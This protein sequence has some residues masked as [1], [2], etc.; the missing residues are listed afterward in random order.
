MDEP[1]QGRVGVVNLRARCRG[2]SFHRL[3]DP[4]RNAIDTIRA[5][6][7]EVLFAGR[8]VVEKEAGRGGMGVVYQAFDRLG[9]RAVALKV[10]HKT[11]PSTVRRFAME[12][13]ALGKLDH[14][15]IVRYLA[16]GVA[17][18]GAPYLALEWV[19]G[20]S[21]RGRLARA[22]ESGE[23]L[24]IENVVELGQRLAGAL[25]AA[26]AIGIVHR[27]V[28]PSN[29]LLVGGHL[30]R[31]KLV[32]FGIVRNASG[33]HV[34]TSG[35]VVGTVGY[36]APEQARGFERLDGRADLFSLGCVLF[37]CLTNRDVFDGPD[38]MTMLSML[39]LH[40][41]PRIAELR[42]DVP[43]ELDALV[44]RLLAKEPDK[45]PD[46]ATEV[47]QALVRI[48]KNLLGETRTSRRSWEP[49]PEPPTDTPSRVDDSPPPTATR[50]PLWVAAIATAVVVL[51]IG[52]AFRPWR[53]VPDSR[54]VAASVAP[55][56]STGT[57]ITSL[58]ASASCDPE[59]VTYYREGLSELRNA[60]WERARTA[61]AKAA[62]K[63]PLCPE[64]QL[65]AAIIMSVTSD[66]ITK[67]REQ[68]AHATDLRE[69]LSDRDR[70][71][72]YAL[73]P[74]L[75][76]EPRDLHA[77]ARILEE[78]LR[79]FPQ[80]AELVVQRLAAYLHEPDPDH[81]HAL[82]LALR[83]LVLDPN[84][85]YAWMLKGHVLALLGRSDEAQ[86]A[87]ET[88]L[89]VAPGAGDCFEES[90]FLFE[91]H[92]Q[93][94]RAISE[95]RNWL[96]RMPTSSDAYRHLANALA[97]TGAPEEAIKEAIEQRWS[98]AI[99]DRREV[100]EGR[101]ANLADLAALQGDFANAEKLATQLAEG[102]KDAPLILP[103]LQAASTLVETLV[104][105]GEPARAATVAER[106]SQA[107]TVW[108]MGLPRRLLHHEASLFA[109]LARQGRISEERW[110]AWTAL[111]KRDTE[112]TMNP[113][114][115]WAIHWGT[116]VGT[117]FDAVT[118]W[119][120]RPPREPAEGP[121]F[122]FRYFDLGIGDI[123]AGRVALAAGAI[124]SAISLMEPGMNNCQVLEDP[125][126][127]TRAHLWLG[128]AKEKLGDTDA[129]C[130]AY[131]AVL[132]R[133]GHANP[134]STTA[135][136]AAR[137]SRAL[138]CK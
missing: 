14:P 41:P 130:S 40:N 96:A 33:E 67:T 36:M 2:D 54:A 85:A 125:F 9:E 23:Y 28:K 32:D 74:D 39:L 102:A 27:D 136:E 95:T 7:T 63:D 114:E 128:M 25:A 131:R 30:G 77:R 18:D 108:T 121:T 52:V 66:A 1:R 55:P 76:S 112:A 116:M 50:R 62:A 124:Q 35:T 111:W 118:T 109:A 15:N 42:P 38:P 69:Q 122:H 5:A 3:N 110:R 4:S 135:R 99:D 6:G 45:R 44:L 49:L 60:M 37:R 46:S 84:Y 127:N 8:F 19:E 34:T 93:C 117:P 91:R 129:A 31:P 82:E 94:E 107:R 48:G 137:R 73:A 47:Q 10:L 101:F 113:F 79:R 58:P 115:T 83:A 21:L 65:R 80:D 98:H 132:D 126:T 61:F 134:P 72:Y 11:E 120:S 70:V 90:T 103:H 92:G 119:Q 71:L 88:C 87:M 53:R 20:E 17:E 64:A 26:H 133:W 106:Y 68:Y 78:G 97:S 86:Q 56:A 57:I 16:R 89:S 24:A 105:V 22:E 51:F 75:V 59:A 43:A 104:E 12:A 81:E 138:A 100:V 13:D 29:I 123:F